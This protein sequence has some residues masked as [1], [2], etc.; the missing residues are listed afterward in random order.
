[1]RRGSDEMGS[2]E[3]RIMAEVKEFKDG[4]SKRMLRGV[5]EKE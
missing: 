2:R 4:F 5:K 3:E 1:M